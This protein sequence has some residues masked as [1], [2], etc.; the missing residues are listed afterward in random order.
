MDAD[1][2]V[3]QVETFHFILGR[4]FLLCYLV[5]P[6]DLLDKSCLIIFDVALFENDRSNFML[7]CKSIILR[8]T[9]SPGLIVLVTLSCVSCS[10]AL[11]GIS[12]V[13]ILLPVLILSVLNLSNIENSDAIILIVVLCGSFRVCKML[14]GLSNILF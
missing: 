8:S 7:A 12:L 13:R 2:V 10:S 1:V 4:Y 14:V 9:F 6:F 11:R 5:T 3:D